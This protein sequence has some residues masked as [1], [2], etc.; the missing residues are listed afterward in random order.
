MIDWR[1]RPNAETL[2]AWVIALIVLLAALTLLTT[3]VTIEQ[4]VPV[5]DPDWRTRYIEAHS[6]EEHALEENENWKACC[7][8]CYEM[9]SE[10]H[11]QLGL[12]KQPAPGM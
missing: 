6:S 9:R 5:E 8:S 11:R 7:L 12:D 1:W 4:V 2:L 10:T 3:L